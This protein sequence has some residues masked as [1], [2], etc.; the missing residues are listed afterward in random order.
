MSQTDP[1]QIYRQEA[2]ELLEQLEQTLLDL[3]GAPAD[4]DL[5]NTAFRAL[6][7]IKGSGAM[8]GFDRVAAFTHHVETAFDLVR[9]GQVAA[10]AALIAV[11]LAAKDHIRRLVE[12]PDDA[13]EAAGASILEELQAVVAAPGADDPAAPATNAPVPP[14]QTT[15]RLRFRLPLD[16]MAMGTDPLLLL[17]ELRSLG[18]CQVRAD[19]TA[20]PPLEELDATEC[21]IGWDVTVTTDRPLPPAGARPV[22]RTR[23]GPCIAH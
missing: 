13:S 3:E 9:K 2:T 23:Q 10:S 18:P 12:R 19:S 21:H 6:H 7:T 20:V 11:T 17:D 5:V 14:S 4:A 16:A 15:W 1:A 8:F 22:A